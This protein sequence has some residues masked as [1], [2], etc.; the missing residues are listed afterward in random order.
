[1]IPLSAIMAE[2]INREF[3]LCF[4]NNILIGDF[5]IKPLLMRQDGRALCEIDV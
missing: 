2:D 4:S 3:E 1:M 5:Y